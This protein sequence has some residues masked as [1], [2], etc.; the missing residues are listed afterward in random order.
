M[1]SR[2][3]R[4]AEL[5]A[6]GQSATAAAKAA[7]YSEKTAY[8]QGSRLLK[9]TEVAA[10]IQQLQEK[11]QREAIADGSEILQRLTTIVRG[12]DPVYAKIRAAEL[13]LKTDH[14][15]ARVPATKTTEDQE[16]ESD[17]QSEGCKQIIL[18]YIA[19]SPIETV[20]AIK[21][22]DDITP[23]DGHRN[24]DVLIYAETNLPTFEEFEV[25]EP[26]E[27]QETNI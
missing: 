14:A 27:N 8:S 18:P 6:S 26:D 3:R 2:E 10:L 4:F 21:L 22:G 1:N 11:M 24:D 7:G 5:Y 25:D 9:K 15:A 17:E 12:H 23:L 13:L 16:S 20:T 19:G